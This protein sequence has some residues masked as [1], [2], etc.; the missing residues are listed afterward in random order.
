MIPGIGKQIKNMDISDDAF[1]G[2]ESIIYSM[3]PH[4]RANP[5]VL[6]G[7]RRMRIAKGSGTDIQEINRIVKQFDETRRM[8]R[9]MMD[10]NKMSKALRKSKR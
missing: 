3:T 4:E 1:K 9:L 10:K 6:N 8:M 5:G 2:I 7:S